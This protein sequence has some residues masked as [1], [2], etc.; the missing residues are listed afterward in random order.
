M[1]P[2]KAAVA[3]AFLLVA[4]LAAWKFDRI[5]DHVLDM[6]YGR[7]LA[8]P[9]YAPPASLGE[10][11]VQD[12]DYL[13]NLPTVDISFS[14]Q[15]EAKFREM[16]AALRTR[17]ASLTP[18]QFFLGVAE[19]VAVSG[20]AHTN[21]D[22][23][24]WR[25]RLNSAPVR[26]AWFADGLYVVRARAPHAALLG[27]R[28]VAIGGLDPEA[29]VRET[30][31]FIGGTQERNRATSA[32]LMES[33]QALH[34]LHAELPD[35]RLRLRL[36]GGDGVERDV[37]LAAVRPDDAPRAT[38]PGRLISADPLAKEK[39][40]EWRTLLQPGNDVPPSLRETGQLMYS[41]RLGAGDV[42]YLH[43]WRVSNDFEPQAGE[44]ILAALG[45]ES[46]PRWKCIVLDL[47]F[48]DGGE[49]PAIYR[50]LRAIPK[51]LA[52]DGRIVILTD[53]TTFSGAIITA[54]LVKDFGGA[55]AT[56]IGETQG[57]R[58]TF[59]AEGNDIQLPNSRI[60]VH[61]ATGY[62]DWAHGCRELRCYWPNFWYDV[63]VGTLDPDVNLGWT[64]ADYRRG[65][66]T[67]LVRALQ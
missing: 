52:P 32:L 12:I 60:T 33:P 26:L 53:N 35:D 44:A 54:A 34:E 37:E 59:W 61:T 6:R 66:D 13:A 21:V 19:A 38:R 28:V 11:F 30:G 7:T 56:L 55:R 46:G 3:A 40:G 64:F 48:N 23:A 25:E 65:V 41:A 15:E 8:K 58:L 1:K 18:V 45:P 43:L 62:H 42:L 10:A 39:P 9:A 2:V 67:V 14:A 51:R 31:R 63:A 27:E 22:L 5:V 57:D 29:L 47:R 49:Y 36:R 20:N 4:G 17:A 16:L 50:A 24:A